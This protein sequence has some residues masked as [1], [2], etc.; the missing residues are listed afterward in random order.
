MFVVSLFVCLFNVIVCVH[1]HFSVLF[2]RSTVFGTIQYV[3]GQ[4]FGLCDVLGGVLIN[5]FVLAVF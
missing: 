1:D 5:L 3:S 4:C 2:A